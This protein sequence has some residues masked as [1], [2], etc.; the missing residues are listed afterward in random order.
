MSEA[1][2]IEVVDVPLR[3]GPDEPSSH[4]LLA[5]ETLLA[6]ERLAMNQPAGSLSLIATRGLLHDHPLGKTPRSDARCQLAGIVRYWRRR[7][8]PWRRDTRHG[9]ELPGEPGLDNLLE[10]AGIGPRVESCDDRR[11]LRQVDQRAGT[12]RCDHLGAA[13][14][15]M[16]PL[17]HPTLA[18][19]DS[20]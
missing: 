9:L 17:T 3:A 20:L 15:S 8:Q 5:I 11:M 4:H 16:R 13:D 10:V 7:E 14:L 1:P 12:I 18:S 2:P 6:I 19:L